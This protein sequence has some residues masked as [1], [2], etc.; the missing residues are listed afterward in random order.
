MT[1]I[2]VIV[3]VFI[4][5]AGGLAV[6]SGFVAFLTVFGI[7]PRLT[8]LTRTMKMV[9]YYEWAIVLGAVIG[10]AATLWNPVLH[11]TP[12]ILV[13]IGL[14]SGV[15][16]GMV[17]AALTEVLNVLPILAKRIG[18]DGQIVIL[19]MAIVFG[20]IFGSLYQWLYFVNQ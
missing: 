20:K 3:V 19:L 1:T 2:N 4:G 7:I 12:Y 9:R 8:Q 6:G 11:I 15:F 13:P 17:A 18:I 16:V 10:A 14:A 5:L